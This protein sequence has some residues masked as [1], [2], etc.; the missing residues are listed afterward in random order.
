MSLSIAIPTNPEEAS[1]AT[2][3]LTPLPSP[4]PHA[5]HVDLYVLLDKSG[6]MQ[7]RR[8][9]VVG[10]FNEFVQKQRRLNPDGCRVSLFTFNEEV[11]EVYFRRPLD[12]VP[13]LTVDDYQPDCMTALRDAMGHVLERIEQ[14]R[15][16]TSTVL[17]IVMTDG[18]E[19]ASITVSS[20]HLQT[21]LAD[22]RGEITYMGSN[23]DAIL[24]GRGL[25]AAAEASLNYRDE[26][27]LDAMDSLGN[28]VGRVRRG[29]SQTIRYTRRER[30]RSS[31]TGSSD[32]RS[33]SRSSSEETQVW[34]EDENMVTPHVSHSSL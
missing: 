33:D 6:S 10:G 30:E 7:P 23:Q 20:S 1:T 2:P 27:L 9:S 13:E 18:E 32:S 4:T 14:E 25:G 28:A 5:N 16:D 29:E 24:N 3:P 31:G 8:N 21:R 15:E 19:N 26:N 17:L 12:Q 34:G 11:H 22:F